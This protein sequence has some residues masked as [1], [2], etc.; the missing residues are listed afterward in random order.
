MTLNYDLTQTLVNEHSL[1][2]DTVELGVPQKLAG[3]LDARIDSPPKPG[4]YVY[5]K[6]MITMVLVNRT[7]DYWQGTVYTVKDHKY[8]DRWAEYPGFADL[9]ANFRGR[10]DIGAFDS[11]LNKA[12]VVVARER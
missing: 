2:V 11:Y 8:V 5:G 7:N 9:L 10:V 3:L 6:Y 12:G 1:R 4:D